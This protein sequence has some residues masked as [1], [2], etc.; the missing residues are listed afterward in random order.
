VSSLPTADAA[1][2]AWVPLPSVSER[3]GSG[4]SATHGEKN[5]ETAHVMRDPSTGAEMCTSHGPS[6]RWRPLSR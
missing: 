6:G 2:Q 5:A 1:L 4:P 3:S